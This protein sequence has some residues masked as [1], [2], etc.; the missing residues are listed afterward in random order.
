L[1]YIFGLFSNIAQNTDPAVFNLLG[2][3]INYT[4]TGFTVTGNQIAG[5]FIFSDLHPGNI[6]LPVETILFMQFNDQGQI[7][8]VPL[9]AEIH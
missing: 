5:S 2:V 8:E 4:L 6:S 7:T 3:P 1:K 9:S